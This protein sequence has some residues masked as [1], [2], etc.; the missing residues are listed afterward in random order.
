MVSWELITLLASRGCTG[1]EVEEGRHRQKHS[2]L[3]YIDHTSWV[4]TCTM[5]SY[6]KYLQGRVCR[7]KLQY[8]IKWLGY[9]DGLA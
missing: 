2:R 4:L 9:E 6:L 1:C 5:Q 7:R 8:R 3:I